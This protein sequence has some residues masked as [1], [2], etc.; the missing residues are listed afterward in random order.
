M[1]KVNVRIEDQKV[2]VGNQAIPLLSGE[3]H[4]W[5]LDP[6]NW[7]GVLEKVRLLGLD[8]VATYVCWDFH[9]LSPGQYDF[10]GR[11]DPKRNLVGFLDLLEEMGF[12][13]II[14]PG[15]YIYSEWAQAGVPKL[16]AC[17]HRL[18]P[19]YLPMAQGWLEAVAQVI[20]S[21]QAS[22]GGRIILC[23]VENELDCWPHIYT[24]SLGL[25][26][27]PGLF[28]EFL[29]ERYGIIEKLNEAWACAYNSFAAARAVLTLPPGRSDW[30]PRYLDYYRFKHWYVVRGIQWAVDVLCSLGI[31]VPLYTNTIAVHSNEPWAAME[32]VAGLNGVDLYPSRVFHHLEEHRKYLEAVRYLRTYSCLPYVAEFEAGIWH[33]AQVESQIGAPVPSHYRMAAISAM[34]A[35]VVGWNWYMIANRD[36]W[37]MSPINELGRI[38]PDIYQVFAQ[39]VSLYSDLDPSTLEKEVEIAATFDPLQQAAVHPESD[40]LS[41]LYKAGLDY[42]FYDLSLGKLGRIQDKPLMFYAGDCWLSAEGQHCLLD[43]IQAGG[44]LVCIGNAPRFDDSLRPLNLLEIPQ[45][46]GAVGDMG[47]ITLQMEIAGGSCSIE[48]SWFEIFDASPGIA[49]VAARASIDENAI[50]EMQL[51]CNIPTGDQYTVGFTRLIGKGRLTYLGLQ[52]SADL[53]I[54]LCRLFKARMPVRALTLDVSAALFR[55]KTGPGPYYLLATNNGSEEKAA[56]FRLCPG[57]FFK[58]P[59]FRNLLDGESFQA[60]DLERVFLPMRGKDA[61]VWEIIEGVA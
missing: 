36:N 27:L 12:W 4:Y 53:L 23:Q 46:A 24:E 20:C 16:A 45:P 26:N 25:G 41:G 50:E 35:G 19:I 38:R 51:H 49:L 55:R 39:I 8:V 34:Q 15:P 2:W 22:R 3:V 54:G 32:R 11:T 5:R 43:Y 10:T 37:Y 56:E 29:Q 7:R 28:Q 17:T 30:M 6:N 31:E 9:E 58:S 21:R 57:L 60:S 48:T 42:D 44:H 13:I 14:R 59:V 33:G 47:T 40:L 52:A 61:A 18:D 1:K